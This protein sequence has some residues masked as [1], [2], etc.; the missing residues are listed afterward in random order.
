MNNDDELKARSIELAE[1]AF[2]LRDRA[3]EPTDKEKLHAAGN[4]LINI[5]NP[6]RF[7]DAQRML[8]I[9]GIW[10]EDQRSLAHEMNVADRGHRGS[11]PVTLASAVELISKWIYPIKEMSLDANDP[12]NTLLYMAQVLIAGDDNEEYKKAIGYLISYVENILQY[13]HEDE[14][15]R[16]EMADTFVL[17]LRNVR[18]A[19]L[20]HRELLYDEDQLVNTYKHEGE[21][22]E[23][24]GLLRHQLDE[25][26]KTALDVHDS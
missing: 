4:E 5:E 18:D 10:T 22:V 12:R 11:A 3:Q 7:Y 23:Q 25:L 20:V 17:S 14:I 15:V 24:I 16:D 1:R 19:L 6:Q 13:A 2:R 26:Y 21:K 9:G 8:E